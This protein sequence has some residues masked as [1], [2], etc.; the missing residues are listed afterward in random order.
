MEA[1]FCLAK[2]LGMNQGT[3]GSRLF[4]RWV[5]PPR[6]GLHAFVYHRQ[7][8]GYAGGRFVLFREEQARKCSQSDDTVCRLIHSPF[9]MIIPPEE[10]STDA[11]ES[12]KLPKVHHFATRI[13][14]GKAFASPTRTFS[15]RTP[16]RLINNFAFKFFSMGNTPNGR[17]SIFILNQ[18]I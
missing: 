5:I 4:A 2:R 11:S 7:H 18:S 8:D 15:C 13:S 3:R 1:D 6:Q 16:H 10:A 9:V 17:N 14:S 12:R